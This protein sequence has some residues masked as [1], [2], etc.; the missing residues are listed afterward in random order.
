M[1]GNAMLSLFVICVSIGII[2]FFILIHC[3]R[4]S[5]PPKAQ[6]VCDIWKIVES[7]AGNRTTSD[8]TTQEDHVEKTS[9][10]NGKLAVNCNNNL[11]CISLP[12]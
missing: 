12:E 2:G 4:T 10:F 11:R 1:G 6:L 7:T 9:R 8:I 3:K 5:L